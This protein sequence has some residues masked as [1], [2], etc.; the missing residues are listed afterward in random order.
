[1]KTLAVRLDDELHARIGMLSKLS[2][3]TVTDTIRTAIEKHLDTLAGDPAITAKAEELR[4]EI[5]KEAAVQQQALAALFAPS[6]PQ[7][8][9]SARG[10]TAKG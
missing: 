7:A 9:K 3:M 2:G 8:S 1:M 6:S 4:A 10:R 5:E